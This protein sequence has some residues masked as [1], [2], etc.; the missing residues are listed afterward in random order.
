MITLTIKDSNYPKLLREISSPPPVLYVNTSRPLEEL[1]KNPA[2]AVVGTRE[3][4][5]Y[6]RTVTQEITR[7]LVKRGIMIVSGLARGVDICAHTTALESNGLTIAV[8]GSGLDC[9]YPAEHQRIAKII[10]ENGA[11]ISEF[12]LGTRPNSPNFPR[13]NRIIS[14]LSLGVVVTQAAERSGTMITASF[15][16]DQ[17]R[18][19][20]AVPGP[21]T[22]PYS[23]GTAVLINKGAKLVTNVND[24]LEELPI[25]T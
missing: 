21:I 22:S 23:R 25:Q 4:T 12:P 3:I 19:V 1:F 15:A 13:R 10:S 16:A 24:I 14:G 8:L 6:G 7:D 18:E 5:Y 9:V 17:G 11:V 2:I 20:F